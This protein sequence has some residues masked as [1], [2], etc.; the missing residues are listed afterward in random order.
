MSYQLWP[1]WSEIVLPSLR[2]QMTGATFD[3]ILSNSELYKNGDETLI[4]KARS[5]MAAK[6]LEGRLSEVVK[7]SL[8]SLGQLPKT[9]TVQFTYEGGGLLDTPAGDEPGDDTPQPIWDNR[10]LVLW[11]FNH[12]EASSQYF[13][14][15]LRPLLT[16]LFYSELVRELRQIAYKKNSHDAEVE[17]DVTHKTLAAALGCTRETVC[18]NLQR[19]GDISTAEFLKNKYLHWF[20]PQSFTVQQY[21]EPSK[22]MTNHHTHFRVM[23]SDPILP[24]HEDYLS[25][26][27][28]L[29]RAS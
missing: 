21:H 15:Y 8:I 7:R 24:E 5:E 16:P 6:W 4:I 28:S 2:L 13:R 25:D 3:Q 14:Y 23:M 27:M 1:V 11:R 18:R 20:I 9:I 10:E 19:K 29:R 17:I 22:K 12:K 26:K